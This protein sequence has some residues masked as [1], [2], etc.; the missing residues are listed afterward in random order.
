MASLHPTE[1]RGYRELFAFGSSLFVH[2]DQLDQHLPPTRARPFREGA[3]E[4]RELVRQLETHAAAY[5]LHG[6][7]AAQGL[8]NSIGVARSRV[9]NRFVETDRATRFALSEVAYVVALLEYLERV[10]QT[11]GDSRA[12]EFCS[13]WASR[14]SAIERHARVAGAELGADPDLAMQ[15]YD[16]SLLGKALQSVGFV[17]GSVG[18]W[19]D[20]QAAKRR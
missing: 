1:H 18:E 11:R 5:D 4:A 20:R 10:A 19:T 17:L 15:P 2:W 9:R 16:G 7:P 12:Q 14:M 8:G 6:K 3:E 13:G